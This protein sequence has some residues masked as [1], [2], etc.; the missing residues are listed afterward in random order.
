M[1]LIN[2]CSWTKR[3]ELRFSRTIVFGQVAMDHNERGAG[4]TRDRQ[5]RLCCKMEGVVIRIGAR[6]AQ[7][8]VAQSV[9]SENRFFSYKQP[10]KRAAGV[11]HPSPALAKLMLG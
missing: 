6:T 7:R 11:Y 8:H 2:N 10:V 9:S 5:E 3:I 1:S 4:R